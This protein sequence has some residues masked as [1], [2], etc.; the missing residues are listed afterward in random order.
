MNAQQR[1]NSIG[2]ITNILTKGDDE[3]VS[4]L[5]TYLNLG[6]KAVYDLTKQREDIAKAKI[7]AEQKIKEQMEKTKKEAETRAK[8]KKTT[9]KKT[10]KVV[11]SVKKEEVKVVEKSD[12]KVN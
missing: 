11:K 5:A 6:T 1:L 3:Q 10:K 2:A 12:P 4:V 9:P 7:L 8:A